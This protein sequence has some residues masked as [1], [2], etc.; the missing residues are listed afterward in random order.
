MRF[1]ALILLMS[2]S[3]TSSL[4]Y[5]YS[6]SKRYLASLTDEE[7]QVKK[8]E[9]Q[10][11][12]PKLF[13]SGMDS[14]FLFVKLYDENGELITDVDP[15]DLTLS[16]S[17][18]VE[19]KPFVF[20]QGVYRTEILP[21]VKSKPI[22][23]R[24]DW[25]ERVLSSEIKLETT[26]APLK[27]EL[28]P[29]SHDF[30][31][32]KSVGEINVGRGSATPETGTDSFTFENV[33]DNRIVD[34]RRNPESHRTFTFNYLEQAR[35]NL[36]LEVDD[37]PN[38]TVSYTMHSIFM[39]FPRKN[40]FLVEQLSGTINVTLPTGEKMIFQSDSKEIVD[41]VFEEG[42]VDVSKDRTKRSFADLKYRGRG[43]VLRVNSRGQSPQLGEFEKTKI[44]QEY[45]VRGSADVLI[46]NGTTGQRCRRPKDDFWEPIDVTPIAF[47]F[48]TDEAFDLYLRENCGFGL[49]KL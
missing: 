40:L 39:F 46:V 22:R 33:G 41:G 19:A 8:I 13:A 48:P 7:V 24:V 30:F 11:K 42:P 31:Q 36:Q 2:C 38:G 15:V 12:H 1:L 3:Q 27:D 25:Q 37:A 32:T 28:L 10:L 20:K 5:K 49:P 17:E 4:K 16:T 47:K 43:I 34:E 45:G 26:I 9:G 21:R 44:D 29:L 18:D 14:T 6:S 35:Q 23:M